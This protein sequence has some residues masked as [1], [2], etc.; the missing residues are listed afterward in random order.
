MEVWEV[1]QEAVGKPIADNAGPVAFKGDLLLVNVSSSTWLH[2][3]RFLEKEIVAKI[4]SAVGNDRVRAIM[5][6]VGSF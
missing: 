5:F 3:M 6:K 1:W 2:H 4:N